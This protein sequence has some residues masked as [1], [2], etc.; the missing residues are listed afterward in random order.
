MAMSNMSEKININ[1]LMYNFIQKNRKGIFIFFGTVLVLLAGFIAAVSIIG[2]V[3]DKALSRAEEFNRRYEALR[4]D[5][6]EES[7]AE[8]VAG[9]LQELKDFAE[10]TSGYAGA[11]VWSIIG[12]IHA[13]KKEWQEAETAYTSAAQAAAKTYLAPAAYFN[14]A[15][16]AEEQGNLSGAIELYTRSVAQSA[17]FPAAARAQFA[18]GR[19]QE[20]LDN[21]TAAL[22][23]YRGLVAGWPADPVWTNLAQSRIILLENTEQTEQDEENSSDGEAE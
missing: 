4:F 5:I 8:E 1:E 10:K 16:A 2:A 3:R 15:A 18:V 9:L 7:K 23:A 11:R 22:E 6:N 12:G 19:L 13:D 21:K 14:A 17:V 20:A